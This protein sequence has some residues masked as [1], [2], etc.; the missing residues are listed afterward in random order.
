MTSAMVA[1]FSVQAVSAMTAQKQSGH[2]A[3]S[4][5]A[6]FMQSGSKAGDMDKTQQPAADRTQD[7]KAAYQKNESKSAAEIA[8][9]ADSVKESERPDA[10]AASE[11]AEKAGQAEKECV[12]KIADELGVSEEELE[13]ALAALGLTVTDLLQQGNMNLLMAQ[14]T[15]GSTVEIV[16]DDVMFARMEQMVEQVSDIFAQT[17]E[18]LGMTPEQL[19]DAIETAA[20][21]G[22]AQ[23]QMQEATGISVQEADFTMPQTDVLLGEEKVALTEETGDKKAGDVLTPE[24]SADLPGDENVQPAGAAK[25]ELTKDN[26]DDAKG[27]YAQGQQAVATDFAVLTDSMPKAQTLSPEE[28]FTSLTA[29][30]TRD[31]I[32][33]IAEYVK[34]HRSQQVTELEMQ[35]NPASLGNIHLQVVSKAGTVSAQMIAQDQAVAAALESQLLQVKESLEAQGLKIDAVE[36]TVA[37]HEFEQNLDREGKRQEEQARDAAGKGR[38]RILDLNALAGGGDSGEEELTDA[39]RLQVEMMRMGG[40]RLNFRV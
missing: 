27:S 20:A 33:Q 11:I 1:D 13:Q 3:G 32:D 19:L 9:K 2:D 37:S 18:E 35:L 36:V 38:R 29:Q 8:K 14:I 24:D 5:F 17:A 16:T 23:T 22:K 40:N 26:Q 15:G 30:Q 25:Q 39:E 34:L 28:Q 7:A 10:R 21:R 31:V 6:Y 12:Q 4:N